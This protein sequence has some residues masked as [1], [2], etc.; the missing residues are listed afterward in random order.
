MNKPGTARTKDERDV[1]LLKAQEAREKIFKLVVKIISWE[2]GSLDSV[3][4][5]SLN[6]I[7]GQEWLN[8]KKYTLGIPTSADI[9]KV[10]E[11]LAKTYQNIKD[12]DG[13][14]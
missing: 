7:T 12:Q 3:V 1:A 9:Q 13:F 8:Y 5:K 2:S 11:K 10:K 6:K 14:K 4:V